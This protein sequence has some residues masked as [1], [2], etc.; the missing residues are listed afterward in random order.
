MGLLSPYR[1]LDLTNERGLLAGK[2]FADPGADVIQL[3]P[4]EGSSARQVG[5]F[6]ENGP[7]VGRSLF[8]DAYACNKWGITCNLDSKKGQDLFCKLCLS[9]DFLFESEAPGMMEVRGL[10]YEALQAINP[11]LIS[12]CLDA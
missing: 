11:R 7:A 6:V 3:E 4:I 2:M 8:W 12:A 5:P 1:V 10:S 9:A